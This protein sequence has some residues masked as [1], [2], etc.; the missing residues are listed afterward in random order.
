MLS[1][2]VRQKL[3]ILGARENAADLSLRRGLLEADTVTPVVDRT[4]PLS[5]V[6]DA[7]QYL[8]EGKARACEA[9][10]GGGFP[11]LRGKFPVV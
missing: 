1:P 6:A 4:Y 3:G 5:D 7:I 2:L 8:Q 11:N 9:K 10:P